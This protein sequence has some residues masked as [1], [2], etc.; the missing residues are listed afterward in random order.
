MKLTEL[1][2]VSCALNMISMALERFE[3]GFP[4]LGLCLVWAGLAVFDC[5]N[6]AR[7]CFSSALITIS[8]VS[9]VWTCSL[10]MKIKNRSYAIFRHFV[11]FLN[12]FKNVKIEKNAS[13]Y[14][15]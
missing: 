3:H 12:F 15:M 2:T 4:E 9:N 1:R 7:L 6:G 10:H 14:Q 5:E 11:D 8:M 13:R